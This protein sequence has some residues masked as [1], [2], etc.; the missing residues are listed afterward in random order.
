MALLEEEE[1]RRK[2]PPL[3]YFIFLSGQAL[4]EFL[5]GQAL[6]EF[7]KTTFLSCQQKQARSYD[8]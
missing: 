5:K 8:I 3:K 7:L 1:N 4:C 6:C 2:E